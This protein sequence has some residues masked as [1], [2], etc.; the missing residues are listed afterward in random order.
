MDREKFQSKA[1]KTI[2][3]IFDKIEELEVKKNK[4][5]GKTKAGYEENIAE[6]KV[7]KLELQAR[8]D[9][10]AEATEENWE[11]VK[12]AFSSALDSFK[13]GFSKIASLFK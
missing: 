6:L 11:E 13:E 1:K 8:Y 4:A 5:V 7:K 3:E 12:E 2:D 10:L 9:K